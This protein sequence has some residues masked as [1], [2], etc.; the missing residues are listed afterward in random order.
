MES[1]VFILPAESSARRASS[2]PTR[3]GGEREAGKLLSRAER[4]LAQRQASAALAMFRVA[5]DA[6]AALSRCAAG[7]WQAAMLLGDFALAWRESDLLRLHRIA[8]PHRFWDG[9]DLRGKRVIL[10]CLHGFGDAVQFLRFLPRLVRLAADLVVETAPE[11]VELCRCFSGAGRVIP[12][13]SSSDA[14]FWEDQIELMELAYFFRIDVGDLPVAT[15][16]LRIPEAAAAEA[17]SRFAPF[18]QRNVGVVWEAG[19]WDRTRS[20]PLELLAPLF[21]GPGVRFWSLQGGPAAADWRRLGL[22]AGQSMATAPGILRLAA[23]ISRMDL[24]ITVDTLAAHLAGALGIP[25]WIL[26]KY[27]ADWRWMLDGACSPWYPS[28]RLIRQQSPGDWRSVISELR[29]RQYA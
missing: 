22:D 15:H 26:L 12:W 25:A 6:G 20:I 18:S 13:G 19:G 8:D 23:A 21:G 10:R 16:Y 5:E 1:T 17:A 2:R 9:R 29:A 28:L 24:V 3:A 27:D 14:R 7:R 11:L 4:L